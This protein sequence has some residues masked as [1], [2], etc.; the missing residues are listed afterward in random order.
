M[1]RNEKVLLIHELPA[2]IVAALDGVMALQG[3]RRV[4][5][6]ALEEDFTPLLTEPEGPVVV[7]LSQSR[8]DWTA[9]FSSLVAD[10]ESQL[11]ETL[12]IESEQPLA[13]VAIN[14]DAERYAYRYFVEGALHEE[15]LP[16]AAERLDL[17]TL[18]EK[19]TAHGIP[20]ELIDDRRLQFGA[21]H[22]MAGY[23]RAT[24]ARAS[25]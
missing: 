20:L 9:C 6:E 3:L 8:D 11:A 12:A 21:E 18:F 15:Y 4:A 19:L 22:I 7:V 5:T 23:Q 25:D 10:D 13:Y 1:Q 2:A 17:A 14:E 24:T 16:D